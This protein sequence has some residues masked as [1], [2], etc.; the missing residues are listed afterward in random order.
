MSVNPKLKH[1]LPGFFLA[2]RTS[3]F[4]RFFFTACLITACAALGDISRF[5]DLRDMPDGI[6]IRHRLPATMFRVI[7]M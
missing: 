6:F 7:P 4:S 2:I 5:F 1:N 3:R